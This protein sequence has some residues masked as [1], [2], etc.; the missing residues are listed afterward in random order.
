MKSKFQNS[1]NLKKALEKIR[2]SVDRALDKYLPSENEKP[3]TLHKAM[4]Y[5][6]FSGG[7]RIRPI[8]VL[9]SCKAAGGNAKSALAL[10]VAV[11][12]VHTYS[13]IHDDLPSMD[14]DDFRRGKPTC[15]KVF[16]EAAA[17]L[18]GDALLTLSFKIIADNLPPKTAAEAIKELSGAIGSEGMVGGQMMDLESAGRKKRG[19]ELNLINKL[20]TAK[21]FE[22][23]TKLGAIAAGAGKRES[24]ALAKYGASFGMAFQIV[25]DILDKGDYVKVFGI[26]K[27]RADAEYLSE[28]ANRAVDIFGKK[29]GRLKEIANNLSS[30]CEVKVG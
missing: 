27:A 24:N 4:R 17:I 6:V 28:K 30:T 21:L 11:E 10:A 5:S 25:D 2:K 13:L 22:A 8:L 3:R 19:A 16:G 18:A 26:E 20:K 7:K 29:G 1:N 14:N 15:H 9:E 23:S 12:I